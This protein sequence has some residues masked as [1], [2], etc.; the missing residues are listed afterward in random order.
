MIWHENQSLI[1]PR[2]AGGIRRPVPVARVPG[3]DLSSLTATTYDYSV[4]GGG[5]Y[6]GITFSPDG[7][8][9]NVSEDIT[10]PTINPTYDLSTAWDLSTR[11]LNGSKDWALG[12]TVQPNCM[13]WSSDGG[14]ILLVSSSPDSWY[15]ANASTPY[16]FSTLGSLLS[17]GVPA[18]ETTAPTGLDFNADGTVLFLGGSS[19]VWQYTLSTPYDPSTKGSASEVLDVSAVQTGGLF[20]MAFSPDGFKFYSCAITDN[21]IDQWNLGTAY[22]LGTATHQPGETIA[23]GTN[24]FGMF[25]SLDAPEIYVSHNVTNRVLTRWA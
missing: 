7:L 23:A 14:R 15:W 6:Q 1:D 12:I 8:L 11:V 10:S 19:K 21:E 4:E 16:D 17:E 24:P 13:R 3:P 22:A 9:C 20:G 25:V 2:I 18:T 5:D